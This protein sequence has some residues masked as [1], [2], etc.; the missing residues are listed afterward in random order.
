MLRYI[1]NYDLFLITIR[2]LKLRCYKIL[3][4][5]TLHTQSCR[6]LIRKYRGSVSGSKLKSVGNAYQQRMTDVSVVT[7]WPNYAV[8]LIS[9]RITILAFLS[10]QICVI[11][12]HVIGCDKTSDC[13][14]GGLLYSATI[15]PGDCFTGRLFYRV[16][17]YCYRGTICI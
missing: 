6:V 16:V 17:G 15:L 10:F 12:H 11:I 1:H 13:E 3:L 7:T 4:L 5:S 8:S 2:T 9:P 14:T